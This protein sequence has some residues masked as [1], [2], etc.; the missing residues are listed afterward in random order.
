[1]FTVVSMP[2]T[3]NSCQEIKSK[4][5]PN[6]NN[7][8]IVDKWNRKFVWNKYKFQLFQTMIK[9]LDREIP[10]YINST[11]KNFINIKEIKI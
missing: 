10:K 7:W 3:C 5:K 11:I 9:E 1:M 8:I 2:E 4:L 6:P